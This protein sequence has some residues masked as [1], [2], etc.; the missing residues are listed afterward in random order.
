MSLIIYDICHY[1]NA[2]N[3]AILKM[4]LAGVLKIPLLL[5]C[6][7]A[8]RLRGSFDSAILLFV[9]SVDFSLQ[10]TLRVDKAL[11]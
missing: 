3:C 7:R 4:A 8:P 6:S 5:F 1:S 10:L 11:F 2:G 9:T